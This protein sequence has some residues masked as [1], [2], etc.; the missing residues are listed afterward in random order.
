MSTHYWIWVQVNPTTEISIAFIH[1]SVV[2]LVMKIGRIANW[3][4]NENECVVSVASSSMFAFC[5]GWTEEC[6]TTASPNN[7]SPSANGDSDADP[8]YSLSGDSYSDTSD[9]KSSSFDEMNVSAL[10]EPQ[11]IDLTT[12]KENR[13]PKG[14]KK[15]NS[16]AIRMERG[17][18]LLR[19]TEPAYRTF[20]RGTQIPERKIRLPR[21]AIV[22]TEMFFWVL[23]AKN[24]WY[25][26]NILVSGK[27]QCPK[28]SEFVLV[29]HKD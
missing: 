14:R 28:N 20:K 15:K 7:E 8:N 25:Y 10:N 18:K 22:C 26:Q 29:S 27:Y 3:W 9:N 6:D 2:K 11:N 17:K 4:G 1:I 13:K 19:N 5:Q 12:D 24:T 23:R 16:R 21:G